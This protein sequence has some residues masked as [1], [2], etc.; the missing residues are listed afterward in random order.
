MNV[1]GRTRVVCVYV[2]EWVMNA[3]KGRCK[4]EEK[5]KEKKGEDA[6]KVLYGLE[7]GGY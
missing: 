4:K 3:E 5:E 6:R 2:S 7:K 1:N